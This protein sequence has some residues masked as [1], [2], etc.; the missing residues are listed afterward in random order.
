M[1][2]RKLFFKVNREEQ[3]RVDKRSNRLQTE[4][5]EYQEVFNSL[6]LFHP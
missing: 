5:A 1:D 6:R 2:L 3:D 4:G